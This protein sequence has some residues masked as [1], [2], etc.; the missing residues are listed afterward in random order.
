MR[1]R[2]SVFVS[3]AGECEASEGQR[4]VHP[5]SEHGPGGGG[6]LSR[7]GG[8]PAVS[9]SGVS[10]TVAWF[11]Q[12]LSPRQEPSVDQPRSRVFGRRQLTQLRP[13]LAEISGVAWARSFPRCTSPLPMNKRNSPEAPAG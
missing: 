3:V 4:P 13:S 12:L 7:D 5:G 10:V 1:G 11:A 9:D 8:D 6:V 2:E